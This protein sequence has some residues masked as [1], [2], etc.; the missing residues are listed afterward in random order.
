MRIFALNCAKTS[1]V[2]LKANLAFIL[3]FELLKYSSPN[4]N[5]EKKS[6]ESY[7]KGFTT[8]NDSLKK[9]DSSLDLLSRLTWL[10]TLNSDKID[11]TKIDYVQFM[12]NTSDQ[13][14]PIIKLKTLINMSEIIEFNMVK[15]CIKMALVFNINLT[16]ILVNIL[17]LSYL[18]VNQKIS[19]NGFFF[20]V[21]LCINLFLF[22]TII[23]FNVISMKRI[24]GQLGVGTVFS[25]LNSKLWT[26]LDQIFVK[27]KMNL[28]SLGVNTNDY[29][30]VEVNSN[31][32]LSQ[33]HMPQKAQENSPL[34]SF[35]LNLFFIIFSVCSLGLYS[36]MVKETDECEPKT[37]QDIECQLD[38][39][40]QIKSKKLEK[41]SNNSLKWIIHS[42][43]VIFFL[44]IWDM[45]DVLQFHR[46][47]SWEKT[48][49]NFFNPQVSNYADFLVD[50]SRNKL[51]IRNTSE[52]VQITSNYL[53]R[54]DDSF[55]KQF[56][57]HSEVKSNIADHN[58]SSELG[59]KVTTKIKGLFVVKMH[60]QFAS[61]LLVIFLSLGCCY[62]LL[63]IEKYLEWLEYKKM[64]S[65]DRKYSI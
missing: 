20:R 23:P 31:L 39:F 22:L 8:R 36:Y 44:S 60:A 58:F 10:Y 62:Q 29:V 28:E 3:V 9:H 35:H 40:W 53:N 24:C 17:L 63:S 33:T 5:L 38:H 49:L 43:F 16:T 12:K 13:T 57:S 61:D 55:Y 50:L 2:L 64:F 41:K 21:Q 59:F 26:Y 54:Y 47:N 11:I 48:N 45:V 15:N 4:A 25:T 7:E 37:K 32:M 52:P 34:S 46:I 1:I 65:I 56:F 19:K 6:A 27:S 42:I 18:I 51:S 30:L 14:K